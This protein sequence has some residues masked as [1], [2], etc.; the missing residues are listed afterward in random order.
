LIPP[1]PRSSHTPSLVKCIG[2]PLACLIVD[3]LQI[4]HARLDRS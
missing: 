3:L 4:Y 1:G 2:E